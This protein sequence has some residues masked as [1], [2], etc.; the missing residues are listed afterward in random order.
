MRLRDREPTSFTEPGSFLIGTKFS[1]LGTSS[2]VH[3]SLHSAAFNL[4][5][6]P[7]DQSLRT[8]HLFWRTWG[9]WGKTNRD[10]VS[11]MCPTPQVAL[12]PFLR[13][14]PTSLSGRSRPTL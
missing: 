6:P 14:N 10:P 3:R 11:F 4:A 1:T 7:A 13:Y 9:G 8:K 5:A 12:R 2:M